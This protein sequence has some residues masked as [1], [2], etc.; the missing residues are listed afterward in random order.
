MSHNEMGT[1][2]LC[3]L[4]PDCQLNRLQHLQ[5]VAAR[6]VTRSKK[7]VQ[8]PAILKNLHWLPVKL[9]IYFKLPSLTYSCFHG[10]VPQYQSELI[11]LYTPDRTLQSSR[12]SPQ[13]RLT[14]PGFHNNTC[15][16]HF[17]DRSLRSSAPALWNS[18]SQYLKTD[19]SSASFKPRQLKTHPFSKL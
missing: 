9:R 18:L 16:K 10:T 6:I 8:T 13:S 14:I 12:S 4:L 3:V 19:S 1:S 7:S 17:S 2:S 11:P 5:N 15:K